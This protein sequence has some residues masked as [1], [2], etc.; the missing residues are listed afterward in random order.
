MLR[1]PNSAG[2]LYSNAQRE[3]EERK[4][5]AEE[6]KKAKQRGAIKRQREKEIE[7]KRNGGC[8][9][10]AR[11]AVGAALDAAAV[12]RLVYDCSCQGC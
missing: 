9:A 3:L 12:G 4:K 10:C 2:P 5:A 11:F 6:A 1:S 8:R 7:R